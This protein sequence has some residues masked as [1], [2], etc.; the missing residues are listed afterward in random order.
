MDEY[1]KVPRFEN[2]SDEAAWWFQ[3]RDRIAQDFDRAAIEGKLTRGTVAR[4]GNTPTT[5]IRLDPDDISKA[6]SLAQKRGLK[7]QTYLKALIHEAWSA[8]RRSRTDRS[9]SFVP[10]SP[11]EISSS[12]FPKREKLSPSSANVRLLN[13]E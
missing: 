1:L 12:R 8:K 4:R 7:Y 13:R 3:N 9:Q 11:K 10:D 2:E 6:R 5:T